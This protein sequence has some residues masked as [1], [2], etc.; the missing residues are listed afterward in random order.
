M[1]GRER[2]LYQ[3]GRVSCWVAP[4]RL[5]WLV[6]LSRVVEGVGVGREL[7]PRD[8]GSRPRICAIPKSRNLS[9]RPHI[10]LLRDLDHAIEPCGGRGVGCWRRQLVETGALGT[11]LSIK[12]QVAK[13]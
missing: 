12:G 11:N 1:T 6:V 10:C 8:F 5:Y 2:D 4:L 3:V 7:A 13:L 9:P